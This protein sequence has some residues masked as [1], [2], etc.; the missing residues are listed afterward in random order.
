[1][2]F[3][4]SYSGMKLLS[5]NHLQFANVRMQMRNVLSKRE[6]LRT[7]IFLPPCEAVMAV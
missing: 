4:F 5:K 7:Y 2:P 6:K 3:P 1:M